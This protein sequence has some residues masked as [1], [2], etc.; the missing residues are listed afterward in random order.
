MRFRFI[1]NT[2]SRM[3]LGIGIFRMKSAFRASFPTYAGTRFSASNLI[4]MC[5]FDVFLPAF[6]VDIDTATGTLEDMGTRF[7][8]TDRAVHRQPPTFPL[9]NFS[10]GLSGDGS[11]SGISYLTQL[12]HLVLE[13]YLPPSWF[14]ISPLSWIPCQSCS[15]CDGRSH[16]NRNL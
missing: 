3:K 8:L 4:F 16:K 6:F 2:E 10:A 1:P 14:R 12:S 7:F 15:P 5:F 13:C 11:N 9:I